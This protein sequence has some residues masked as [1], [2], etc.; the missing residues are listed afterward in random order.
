MIVNI[1]QD[2]SGAN[3][4]STIDVEEFKLDDDFDYDNVVLTPKYSAAEMALLADMLKGN[5]TPVRV[6]FAASFNPVREYISP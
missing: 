2:T 6:P 5:V 4:S 1:L 3:A